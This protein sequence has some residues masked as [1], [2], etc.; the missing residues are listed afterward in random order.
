[1]AT[2]SIIRFAKREDGVSF[3]EHPNTFDAQFYAHWDG[4]PSNRGVE[5]AESILHGHKI[6]GWEVENLNT[7]HTDLEYIYY[8][9][10]V[11]GKDTWISIFER[12]D[13]SMESWNLDFKEQEAFECIFVGEPQKLIDKY[14]INTNKD[15]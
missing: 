8:V 1:M 7:R 11:H 5:I 2:R 13:Y 3:S 15:G 12:K 4:Y 6:E 9:W 14:K 10:Q